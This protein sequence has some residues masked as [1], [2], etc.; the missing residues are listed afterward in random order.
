[1]IALTP[2]RRASERGPR[3]RGQATGITAPARAAV[4][5][6][7]QRSRSRGQSPVTDCSNAGNWSK[8]GPWAERGGPS[9]ACGGGAGQGAIQFDSDLLAQSGRSTEVLVKL[10]QTLGRLA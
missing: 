2:S 3:E 6:P 9:G 4:T 1:M 5:R 7:E 10:G 8:F